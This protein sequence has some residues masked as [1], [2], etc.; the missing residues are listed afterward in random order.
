[1]A[2]RYS[3]SPYEVQDPLAH[4]Q[5]QQSAPRRFFSAVGRFF[6]RLIVLALILG[7][8]GGVLFALYRNDVLV[9]IARGAGVEAQYRSLEHRFEQ[10]F[11]TPG[12]GTPRSIELPKETPVAAPLAASPTPKAD[13]A[14]ASAKQPETVQAV[15][16]SKANGSTPDG[17]PI[18]SFD[19]LPALPAKAQPQTVTLSALPPA[20]P[21]KPARSEPAPAR[22][23][24]RAAKAKTVKAEPVELTR[25]I[26]LPK[27]PPKPEPVAKAEPA[28]KPEPPAPKPEP[29]VDRTKPRAGDNPLKAAIRAAM[30]SKP[31]ASD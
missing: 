1:M 26:P 11:G 13:E 10:R 25:S 18:V 5:Y 2:A 8:V 28:P 31:K 3:Y 9:T 22:A 15:A 14:A 7:A 29:E 12:W 19:S 30:A 17:L 16:T 24:Q 20:E 23:P 4:Y 27:A 21:A 6:Y